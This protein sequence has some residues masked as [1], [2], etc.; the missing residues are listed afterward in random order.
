AIQIAALKDGYALT[1]AYHLYPDGPH[2][3]AKPL[4]LALGSA[5]NFTLVVRDER[6]QPVAN[7]RVVPSSRQSADGQQHLVYFQAAGPAQITS[8]SAGRVN[9]GCFERGDRAQVYVQVPG[10][11]WKLHTLDLKDS[12][13][14]IEVSTAENDD[15]C[16]QAKSHL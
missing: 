16:L 15:D 14:I 2:P 11:D 3:A 6:G 4:K 8:D 10:S 1:S 12:T 9:L 13:S 5:T 7:A